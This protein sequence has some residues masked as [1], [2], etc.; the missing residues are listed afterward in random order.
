MSLKKIKKMH[1]KMP[2]KESNALDADQYIYIYSVHTRHLYI[3][4]PHRKIISF[5]ATRKQE[6]NNNIH[7]NSVAT[8][9]SCHSLLMS[10]K[11]LS[12]SGALQ[13]RHHSW[14]NKHLTQSSIEN[15]GAIFK[16]VSRD[17]DCCINA[18]Q[19]MC[20]Y[21][22]NCYY[23]CGLIQRQRLLRLR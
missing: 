17:A 6:D 11:E 22:D 15:K 18:L 3:D 23:W 2:K 10:K 13:W 21:S 19:Y 1:E 4:E 12:P 7:K 14:W 20:R 5:C 16:L 8:Q 9:C